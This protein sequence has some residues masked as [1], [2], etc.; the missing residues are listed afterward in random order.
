MLLNFYIY[1]CRIISKSVTSDFLINQ[2]FKQNQLDL[3]F[4]FFSPQ[5][6]KKHVKS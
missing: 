3:I 4:R 2:H 5:K 1:F 6:R